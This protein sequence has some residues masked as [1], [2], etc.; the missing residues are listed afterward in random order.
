V[1]TA[2]VL[3]GAALSAGC[4]RKGAPPAPSETVA[5]TATAPPA[6]TE[7]VVSAAPSASVVA[8]KPPRFVCPPE[9]VLVSPRPKSGD[10]KT[11]L[12]Y[13]VDR[14]EDT[15]VDKPTNRPA[16]PYYPPDFVRSGLFEKIW[17]KNMGGGTTLEKT[18]P[19]PP[20]PDWEKGK[21]F[22]PMAV[23][24]AGA[25][26][27]AYASEVDADHAC[28]NAG[29]RL[30]TMDEWRAACRGEDDRDFPYGDTY[31]AGK[32]NIFG[33]AHPGILLWDTPSKNHTDPRFNL[34]KYKGSLMLRRTGDTKTCASRWGDDAIYDMNGNIDEWVDDPKGMFLGGFYARSK[35]DGCQS[36]VSAHPP[37]YS[38]Y[39]TGIRCCRDAA[40]EER[41]DAPP[42]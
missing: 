34:V 25:V 33:P 41:D 2:L 6:E 19:L 35:K 12:Q 8:P 38:D 20:L 10:L 30:C 42:P 39:S 4:G 16:T 22:V 29:K 13:C 36:R 17:K 24:K 23:S 31:E 26:P 21:S 32:C 5:V 1:S 40:L 15:V 27:Q 28:V 7:E 3:S 11:K 14:Y 9:M 18:M 37:M